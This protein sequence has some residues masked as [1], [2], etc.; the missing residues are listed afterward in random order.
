M[1]SPLMSEPI[2][3]LIADD[4]PLVLRGLA[5]ILSGH[6]DF[7][8]VALAQ[9]GAEAV[10]LYR[11]HRPDVAM[12]DVRM[13]DMTGLEA[14]EQIR[15]FDASARV[16]MLSTFD[17]DED[18]VRALRLGARAYVLKDASPEEI[19]R[20][21]LRVSEGQ[22]YLP[23]HI[24]DKLLD[25]I[26]EPRLTHRELEVLRLAAGG[27]QN[28]Q[29]AARLGISVGTVKGYVNNIL[30]KLQ[31]RDRTEAVTIGLRRGIIDLDGI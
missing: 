23:S 4:H 13:P 21:V 5:A 9:G 19:I 17:G 18:V 20:A 22:R 27:E 16:V 2:R 7:N 25:H 24:A 11:Q 14:L 26:E 6:R 15:V 29:I 12:L 30:I 3:L 28:K 1:D 10:T 8:I 31:A